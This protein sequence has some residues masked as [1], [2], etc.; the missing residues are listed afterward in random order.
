[1]D[2]LAVLDEVRNGAAK[3]D[4]D[5]R[6][7]ILI[8]F[9]KDDPTPLAT[10][11]NP[12]IGSDRTIEILLFDDGMPDADLNA[13]VQRTLKA[14]TA[15]ARL[16]T[17]NTN[18]GRSAGRN[19]LASKAR[20]EWLLFLDADMQPGD[21]GFLAAY[22]E[23]IAADDFDAA[24]GG[25]VTDRPKDPAYDLHAAL[26]S[27]SDHSDVD[28][29]ASVGATAFCSSNLLVRKTVMFKVPFDTGF[30]GWGWEDIDWAVSAAR[31][32]TLI[33]LDNAA[34]HGG[35]QRAETLLDKFRSGAINYGRLLDKH[36]ELASLPGA[37]AARTIRTIPLQ[38]RLRGLW[39]LVARS[40]A[41]PM[42]L[43]T[44]AVKLWRASWTAEVME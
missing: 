39:S 7:S 40:R 28:H 33:H 41:L 11:L 26:S 23:R 6:L 10:A 35:L 44:L 19:L 8:P 42:R 24:F 1:M 29:R 34:R 43:R 27:A 21:D 12:L 38:A 16:I 36:P 17:S 18:I 20:G 9:Y 5:I 2:D 4:Q 13:D 15:P 22:L 30:K 31:H 3:A 14:M 32:F 25:Y 37:R